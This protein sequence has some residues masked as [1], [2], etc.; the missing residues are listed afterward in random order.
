MKFTTGRIAEL[1]A[2][3]HGAECTR[4][5]VNNF[6][7]GVMNL[8]ADEGSRGERLFPLHAAVMVAA[9]LP[10]MPV[11]G[12]PAGRQHAMLEGS[13]AILNRLTSASGKPRQ[14]FMV[15][16]PG[17]EKGVEFLIGRDPKLVEVHPAAIYLDLNRLVAYAESFASPADPGWTK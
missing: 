14:V 7:V 11:L 4:V 8:K 16:R 2:K 5:D 3:F 6:L 1:A 17:A 9:L 12:G 15:L 10:W 13:R